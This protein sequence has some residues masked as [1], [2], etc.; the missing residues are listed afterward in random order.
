MR[1]EMR[2]GYAEFAEPLHQSM[3]KHADGFAAELQSAAG[4][5]DAPA[6]RLLITPGAGAMTGVVG[7]AIVTSDGMSPR[8]RSRSIAVL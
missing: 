1:S 6:L 2:S 8:R 5:C 3:R 4:I 7:S